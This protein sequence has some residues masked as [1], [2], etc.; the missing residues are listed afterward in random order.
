MVHINPD[1]DAG[2]E[3]N[4]VRLYSVDADKYSDE[5]PMLT[6]GFGAFAGLV[7]LNQCSTDSSQR[8]NSQTDLE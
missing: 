7:A 3:W 4:T 2:G 1:I 6:P 5:N 8:L